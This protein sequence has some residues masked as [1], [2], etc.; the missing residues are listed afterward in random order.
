MEGT[1]GKERGNA[2]I[3]REPSSKDVICQAGAE[4][5]RDGREGEARVREVERETRSRGKGREGGWR[6][7]RGVGRARGRG[8]REGPRGSAKW[9][10]KRWN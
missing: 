1:N 3:E 6:A 4:G 10:A 7:R 5:K 8:E 2:L 9:E